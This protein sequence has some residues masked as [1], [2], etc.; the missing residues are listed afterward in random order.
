MKYTE[1]WTRRLIG[2]YQLLYRK[3][4]KASHMLSAEDRDA[5]VDA[6]TTLGNLINEIT[7]K[8]GEE[9]AAKSC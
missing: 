5:L 6:L 2:D 8:V 1:K 4:T 7:M 9:S 3:M